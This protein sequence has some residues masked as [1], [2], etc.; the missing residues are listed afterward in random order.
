MRDD[1]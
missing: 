1:I